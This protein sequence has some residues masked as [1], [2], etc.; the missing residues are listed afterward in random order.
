MGDDGDRP[1]VHQFAICL[2]FGFI[3]FFD[4]LLIFDSHV[5]KG[6]S[7]AAAFARLVIEICGKLGQPRAQGNP[8]GTLVAGIGIHQR[9]IEVEQKAVA[10]LDQPGKCWLGTATAYYCLL[11][12]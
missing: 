8:I 6:I 9:A 4:E 7:G 3:E 10:F 1:G 11:L 2:L 5:A 12:S